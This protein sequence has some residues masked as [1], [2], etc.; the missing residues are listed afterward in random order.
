[1]HSADSIDAIPAVVVVCCHC[2]GRRPGWQLDGDSDWY[3]V[4]L[5]CGAR[6]LPNQG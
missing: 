5:Q 6:A 2:D 3:Y 1:M 4:L